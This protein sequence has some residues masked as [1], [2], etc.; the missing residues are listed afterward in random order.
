MN[1]RDAILKALTPG[2]MFNQKGLVWRSTSTLAQFGSVKQEEVL[3]ILDEHFQG[4]VSVRPNGKH[5]ENGPLVALNE[6][7]QAD[8]PAAEP[9]AV[10]AGLN[11]VGAAIEGVAAAAN[12]NVYLGDNPHGAAAENPIPIVDGDGAE[13]PDDEALDEQ[14]AAEIEGDQDHE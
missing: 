6:H 11:A 4:A 8:P 9:Q 3:V 12:G 14:L 5:P 7:I 13:V 10:A 1:S 2:D